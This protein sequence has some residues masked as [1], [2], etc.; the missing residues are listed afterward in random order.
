MSNEEIRMT[1]PSTG[2]QKGTK[3]E[4]FDLIPAKALSELAAHFGVGSL[5]YAKHNWR[6][7]Y[8]WGYSYAAMQRHA[9][10][11]WSGEDIDEE[12]GSKH[13]IAAA[14]H[15]LILSVFMDEQPD[16][17]DRF[18]PERVVKKEVLD[19]SRFQVTNAL[20][21]ISIEDIKT[22]FYVRFS[23]EKGLSPNEGKKLAHEWMISQQCLYP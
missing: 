9:W 4:K 13:I 17:D 19:K 15:C 14:W 23:L 22:R 16:K 21:F 10:A 18:R 1:D 20:T 7:G 3:I 2:A 6:K 5:K 12:T 8:D 11:F